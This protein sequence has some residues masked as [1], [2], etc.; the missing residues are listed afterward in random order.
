MAHHNN[1]EIQW[2]QLNGN[3]SSTWSL[4]PPSKH[5][6][7]STAGRL[8]MND[9]WNTVSGANIP[10]NSVDQSIGEKIRPVDR[11]AGRGRGRGGGQRRHTISLVCSAFP[12]RRTDGVS[13]YLGE[14][15]TKLEREHPEKERQ[16]KLNEAM[17]RQMRHINAVTDHQQVASSQESNARPDR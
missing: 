2:T 16:S 6:E 8:Q 12:A 15:H 11:G 9:D 17:S 3:K 5:S 1:G 4:K 13:Q 10:N 7:Q 14:K